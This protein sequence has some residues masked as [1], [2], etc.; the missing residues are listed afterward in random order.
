MKEAKNVAFGSRGD[1]ARDLATRLLRVLRVDL[2][3]R[4]DFGSTPV[5]GNACEARAQSALEN[6][7]R[8]TSLLSFARPQA[9]GDR[10]KP[11]EFGLWYR[12]LP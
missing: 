2:A 8:T 9:V 10:I 11:F 1:L 6:L 3:E 4:C 7:L 5:D 12:S